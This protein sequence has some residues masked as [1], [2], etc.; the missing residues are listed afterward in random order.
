[1]TDAIDNSAGVDTSDHEVNIKIALQPLVDSD[2]LA[3]EQ[4][5]E[6]LAGMTQTVAELVLDD[7]RAQNRLLGVS[8]HHASSMISVHAR[9]ISALVADGHLDRDL[10]FLP[11][12]EQI[13]ERMAV[14]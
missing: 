2:A 14:G 4:R 6:L 1:N 3:I 10:E 9:Q 11:T 12:A 5:N 13:D 8:R 7:N